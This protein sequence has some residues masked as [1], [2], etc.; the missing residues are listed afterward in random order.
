MRQIFKGYLYFC[1]RFFL[2]ISSIPS[3]LVTHSAN[4]TQMIYRRPDAKVQNKS[5]FL[6]FKPFSPAV[7]GDLL[8]PLS[9]HPA[10]WLLCV[11]SFRFLPCY[12][13]GVY[14]CV[15]CMCVCVYFPACEWLCTCACMRHHPWWSL[16]LCSRESLVLLVIFDG[17]I[18]GICV[19]VD[20]KENID[21]ET[22]VNGWLQSED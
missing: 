9:V 5:V 16:C 4:L 1:P 12:K 18:D 3:K 6:P 21:R 7:H 10:M 22:S 14:F 20:M 13:G 17:G 15:L 11:L 2:F 19:C 8:C